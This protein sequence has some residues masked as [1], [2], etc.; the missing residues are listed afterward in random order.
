MNIVELQTP[1]QHESQTFLV[2]KLSTPIAALTLAGA[3]GFKPLDF[4]RFGNCGEFAIITRWAAVLIPSNS[5][6]LEFKP[7]DDCHD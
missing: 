3:F 6:G 4:E 7:D 2:M 5:T 1:T